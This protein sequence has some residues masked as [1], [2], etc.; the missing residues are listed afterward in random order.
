MPVDKRVTSNIEEFVADGFISSSAIRSLMEQFVRK[1]LFAGQKCPIWTNRRFF[2]TQRDITNIIYGAR[3]KAMK[4]KFDQENWNYQ[5]QEWTKD[6]DDYVMFSAD[7]VEDEKSEE[8]LQSNGFLFVYQSSWQRRLLRLYGNELC[9]LDAT[10]RTTKYAIPLFFPCVKTN[11][12]YTVVAIFASQFENSH[13]IATALQKIKEWNPQ[14]FMVDHCEAE[15]N[16]INSC[17]KGI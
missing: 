10:Y 12:D 17:F 1:D 9:L 11:V 5:I 8:I 14:H 16:A 13:T 15:I 7:K 2:P 3:R 6:T 4:S